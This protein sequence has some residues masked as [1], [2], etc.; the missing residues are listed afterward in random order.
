MKTNHQP[1]SGELAKGRLV[2]KPLGLE[3]F[4]KNI[5]DVLRKSPPRKATRRDKGPIRL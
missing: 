3:E 5:A 4:R 1:A 2:K